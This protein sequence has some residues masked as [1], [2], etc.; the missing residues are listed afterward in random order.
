M[1]YSVKGK[2]GDKMAR[3][4]PRLL[5]ET[6]R[7]GWGWFRSKTSCL[8]LGAPCEVLDRLEE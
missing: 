1:V 3:R 6:K 7:T 2:L 4:S 8:K 5:P